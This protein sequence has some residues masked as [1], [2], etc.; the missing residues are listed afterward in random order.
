MKDYT[1][2]GAASLDGLINLHI[3]IFLKLV[4][5]YGYCAFPQQNFCFILRAT[6][7]A[8][9]NRAIFGT[10]FSPRVCVGISREVRARC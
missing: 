9:A 5:Q 2:S 3:S 6:R 10:V 4:T 1:T 7:A 8:R